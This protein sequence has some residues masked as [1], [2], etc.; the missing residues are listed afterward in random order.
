MRRRE[1]EVLALFSKA[2][3]I[4]SNVTVCTLLKATINKL[5]N[6]ILTR[7]NLEPKILANVSFKMLILLSD[8]VSPE[9]IP[10][11]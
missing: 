9:A 5:I 4:F 7:F 2:T 6:L 3:A 11:Y 10:D 1:D 8:L